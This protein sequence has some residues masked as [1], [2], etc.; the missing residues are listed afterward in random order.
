[1]LILLKIEATFAIITFALFLFFWLVVRGCTSSR[2]KSL[3]ELA[4]N[5]GTYCLFAL[6][7]LGFIMSITAVWAF[8]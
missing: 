1:M 5:L 2:D 4:Q 8:I 3:K 6:V 7:F